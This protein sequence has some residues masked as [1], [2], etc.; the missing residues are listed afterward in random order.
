M[1]LTTGL[2][3]LRPNRGEPTYAGERWGTGPGGGRGTND[4][5]E[6]AGDAGHGHGTLLANLQLDGKNTVL[7]GRITY[8]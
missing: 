8:E 2:S 7:D 3:R 1:P 4:R 5:G 6:W